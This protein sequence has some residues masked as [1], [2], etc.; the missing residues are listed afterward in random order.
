MTNTTDAATVFVVDDDP[1]ARKSLCALARSRGL[2]CEEFPS[3]EEFLEVFDGTLPGAVITDLRMGGMNGL[4]LQ[5]SLAE[6]G[7]LLPVIVV[8]GHADV[9]MTVKLMENGAVTLLQKPYEEHALLDAIDKALEQN[10]QLRQ[11]AERIQAIG[12]RLRSL[13]TDEERILEMI[14]E[15]QPNKAI[16]RET[17]ASLRTIDRRR[18]S[19]FDKM[20]VASVAELIQTVNDFRAAERRL[21]RR[22]PQVST[23]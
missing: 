10:E 19:V 15:G 6:H 7:S 20:Q 14:I 4:E 21:A 3:A 16:A 17:T 8:S 13:S 18:R 22:T 11:C 1:A 12:A 9:P 23:T 2:V 5:K